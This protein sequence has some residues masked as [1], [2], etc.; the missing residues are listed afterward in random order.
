MCKNPEQS[1]SEISGHLR[2]FARLEDELFISH[3]TLISLSITG[4][5]SP[6]LFF[7]KIFPVR[8]RLHFSLNDYAV[9]GTAVSTRKRSR[10]SCTEKQRRYAFYQGCVFK[11]YC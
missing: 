4:M 3:Q 10:S 2:R 8:Q 9:P 7:F 11:V 1:L 6:S 5:G